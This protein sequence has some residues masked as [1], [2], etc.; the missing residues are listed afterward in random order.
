MLESRI[1]RLAL[2]REDAEHALVHAT[3]GLAANESLEP[4]DPERKLPKRERPLGRQ[5]TLA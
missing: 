5:A 3:E 4:F 2:Q 1:H